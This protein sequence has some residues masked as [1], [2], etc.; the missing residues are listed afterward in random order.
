MFDLL[1]AGWNLLLM[2][3]YVEGKGS[4]VMLEHL[5]APEHSHITA[6]TH[7]RDGA[8]IKLDSSIPF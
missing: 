1:V 7:H 6:R 3:A 8:S 2:S 5:R 4:N